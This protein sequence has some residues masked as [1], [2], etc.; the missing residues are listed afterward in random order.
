MIHGGPFAVGAVGAP[1]HFMSLNGQ[2]HPRRAQELVANW[3]PITTSALPHFYR[4]HPK[5]KKRQHL[6]GVSVLR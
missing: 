4:S 2:T 6:L 1:I 3:W 5:R